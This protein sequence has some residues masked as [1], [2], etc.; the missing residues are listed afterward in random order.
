VGEGEKAMPVQDG[1]KEWITPYAGKWYRRRDKSVPNHTE[2]LTVYGESFSSPERL[3]KL[4]E[5]DPFMVRFIAFILMGGPVA[6]MTSL[7]NLKKREAI[8]QIDQ[9]DR[10]ASGYNTRRSGGSGRKKSGGG[11]F[12]PKKS[13]GFGL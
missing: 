3:A 6:A 12:R 5:Y 9:R 13:Q 1:S 2:I 8:R 11:A 10:K 7:E 4:M